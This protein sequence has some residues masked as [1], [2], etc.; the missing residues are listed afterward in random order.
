MTSNQACLTVDNTCPGTN[1]PAPNGDPSK[2]VVTCPDG[3]KVNYNETDKCPIPVVLCESLQ[4]VYSPNWDERTVKL[5]TKKS[6]GAVISHV[7][8]LLDGKAVD[9][10]KNPG[11]TEEYTYK[12][13]SEGKHTYSV[14]YTVTQGKLQSASACEIKDE[15]DKPVP[16]ISAA[17]SAKNTTKKLDDATKGAAGAGN[18]IE[19]SLT[20]TN[21]G[22]GTANGYI[23]KPDSLGRI[24][25]YADLADY[26]DANFNQTS[27]QLSWP[28]VDIK[29]GESVT[30][31]FTVKIK[32][33]IPTTAPSLSDP[34][35]RQYNICN[36][37]GNEICIDVEKPGPAVVQTTVETLPNTGPGASLVVTF[38]AMCMIGFFYVRGRILAKEI[39]VIK[40]EYSRGV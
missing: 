17:K 8:F 9:S 36:K 35:G 18:I 4:L 26:G 5:T 16:S 34:A 1:L 33:P 2:C 39:E 6:A 31:T 21:S 38:L 15:V 23:I 25:E 13:L 14:N 24:L 20:T 37:Y 11:A 19:Y 10:K 30:K 7:D 32:S 12:K 28:A 27:Q 40:Y 3:T 29:P 22:N